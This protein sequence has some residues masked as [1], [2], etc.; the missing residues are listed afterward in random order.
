MSRLSELKVTDR[1]DNRIGVFV[2]ILGNARGISHVFLFNFSPSTFP[3]NLTTFVAF[4]ITEILRLSYK[5]CICSAFS[6]TW[7]THTRACNA[8][9]FI[10]TYYMKYINKLK[11]ITQKNDLGF[12]AIRHIC[13]C[14]F[15][16]SLWSPSLIQLRGLFLS[17][18]L[19]ILILIASFAVDPI[20]EWRLQIPIVSVHSSTRKYAFKHKVILKTL[21]RII[22]LPGEKTNLRNLNK[23]E[24]SNSSDSGTESADVSCINHEKKQGNIDYIVKTDCFGS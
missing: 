15:P 23:C 21:K 6:V 10:N 17:Y 12:L 9:H 24:Y 4:V 18:F 20:R 22:F 16:F 13:L 1:A 7:D 19:K 8:V 5:F 11:K 3:H 14:R 2:W